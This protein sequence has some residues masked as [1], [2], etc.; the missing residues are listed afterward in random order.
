[1][2]KSSVLKH[3]ILVSVNFL[4]SG[5]NKRIEHPVFTKLMN[6]IDFITFKW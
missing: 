3:V 6:L 5:K 1:M 4:I 2:S